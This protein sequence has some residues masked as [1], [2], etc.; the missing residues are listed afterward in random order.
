MRLPW[1]ARPGPRPARRGGSAVDRRRGG[2]PCGDAHAR[3]RAVE[4]LPV[5]WSGDPWA[6]DVPRNEFWA[7][8][9]ALFLGLHRSMVLALM[10]LWE[11]GLPPTVTR[12]RYRDRVTP[13]I[14][15]GK[16]AA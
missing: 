3:K 7:A 14:R 5:S 12:S 8:S 13:N 6:S 16:L 4:C 1:A 15:L 10:D 2:L 11:S 9:A